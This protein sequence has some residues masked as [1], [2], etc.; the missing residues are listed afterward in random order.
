MTVEGSCLL[1]SIVNDRPLIVGWEED[2][3]EGTAV[4]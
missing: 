1:V 3:K 2:H 4:R